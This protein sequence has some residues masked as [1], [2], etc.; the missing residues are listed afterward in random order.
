[1]F[2]KWEIDGTKDMIIKLKHQ[3]KYLNGKSFKTNSMAS[4]KNVCN[5]F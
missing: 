5:L 3:T 2:S 1:M 4:I